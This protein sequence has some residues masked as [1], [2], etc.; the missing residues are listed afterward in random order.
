MKVPGVWRTAVAENLT[1]NINK[2]TYLLAL[3]LFVSGG[4]ILAIPASMLG[5]TAKTARTTASLETA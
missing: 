4:L 5:R 3:C 2:G 1:D